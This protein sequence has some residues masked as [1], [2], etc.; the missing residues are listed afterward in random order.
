MST[1]TFS[2][3]K[4]L[5]NLIDSN[6]FD[7]KTQSN[8]KSNPGILNGIKEA[9]F[10]FLESCDYDAR[11]KVRSNIALKVLGKF[12]QTVKA[13]NLF[14][15]G[16]DF[17]NSVNWRQFALMLCPGIIRRTTLNGGNE[18]VSCKA[19]QDH[20]E[21][22][23]SGTGQCFS[24]AGPS[25]GEE[26]ITKAV[27]LDLKNKLQSYSKFFDFQP[28]LTDKP[29]AK[30]ELE[31]G[32]TKYL[33]E[34]ETQFK[35]GS[36]AVYFPLGYRHGSTNQGHAIVCKA[37]KDGNDIILKLFN[38]G[39][40]THLHPILGYTLN[41][42]MRSYSFLP[43][44]VS[45]TAFFGEM[46]KDAFCTL[47]RYLADAP[48]EN[49][50]H[51]EGE[52][53]YDVFCQLALFNQEGIV[54]H[55]GPHAEEY[56]ANEQ[57]SG[58]CPEIA[59][60]M[61]ITDV[62]IDHGVPKSQREKY[63]LNR[64]FCA[65]IAGYQALIKDPACHPSACQLLHD[66]TESFSQQIL[67]LYAKKEISEQELLCAQSV[68]RKIMESIAE[69]PEPALSILKVDPTK[70]F[71]N[72]FLM[73]PTLN[74]SI[75]LTDPHSS[76]HRISVDP[77]YFDA[78]GIGYFEVQLK[79]WIGTAQSLS[80][81][82]A[83]H[84]VADCIRKLPI[85][86][87]TDKRESGIDQPSLDVWNGIEKQKVK[88]ILAGFEELLRTGLRGVRV[89]AKSWG[90]DPILQFSDQFMMIYTVYAI[91]DKLARSCDEKTKLSGFASPFLPCP[92]TFSPD[93]FSSLPLKEDND[94]Y[95]KLQQYFTG[96]INPLEKNDS[97]EKVIFPVEPILP[98]QQY[99]EDMFKGDGERERVQGRNHIEYLSRHLKTPHANT[100]MLGK[101]YAE[102]W[103]SLLPEEVRSLY[104]FSFLSHLLFSAPGSEF[105]KEL[106]FSRAS[107]S[108]GTSGLRIENPFYQENKNKGPSGGN[109]KLYTPSHEPILNEAIQDDRFQENA[110]QYDRPIYNESDRF[111]DIY[112]KKY[113]SLKTNE[114]ICY[115]LS[116][117]DRDKWEISEA[118]IRTLLYITRKENLSLW[119]S[120]QEFSRPENQFLLSHTGVQMILES[121]F[122]RP[123][124]MI[125]GMQQEPESL[126]GAFR[127]FVAQ[128]LQYFDHHTSQLKGI[129]FLLRVGISFETFT[130]S[131]KSREETL[132]RYRK[133][134]KFLEE[135]PLNDKQRSEIF[136]HKAFLEAHSEQEDPAELFKI[137]FHAHLHVS[138]KQV[139]YPWL[140]AV[141]PRLIRKCAYQYHLSLTDEKSRNV[142]CRGIA[143]NCLNDYD[144]YNKL[145]L[146]EWKG[147][148]PQFECG[149]LILDFFNG[150]II[151]KKHGVLARLEE[152]SELPIDSH[153]YEDF[154]AEYGRLFWKDKKKGL[155]SIDERIQYAS[156]KKRLIFKNQSSNSENAEGEQLQFPILEIDPRGQA[157]LNYYQYLPWIHYKKSSGTV[158]TYDQKKQCPF[159][160]IDVSKKGLTYTRLNPDGTLL[161][162]QLANLSSLKQ[163]DY[164]YHYSARYAY[165]DSILCFVHEKTNEVQEV[166]FYRL[167]LQ[168][169]KKEHGL[170]S[171]QYPGF[172]LISQEEDLKSFKRESLKSVYGSLQEEINRFEGMM[173][174]Y[175]P[176]TDQ[177]ILLF[178]NVPLTHGQG[179][180]SREA[181]SNSNAS[182]PG[183]PPYFKY[184]FDAKEKG[185]RT[186][187]LENK[188]IF[189]LSV[190]F[191]MQRD[192]EK[193]SKY[194][195][196][197]K[198]STI[199]NS[200]DLYS[201]ERFIKIHDH[202]A[203]S[204]AF[205]LNLCLF[206]F[207][208]MNLMT[209]EHFQK[210]LNS[211]FYFNLFFWGMDNYKTY[212]H[213]LNESGQSRVPENLRIN[214]GDK[215]KLL[216][217]F[218]DFYEET[219]KDKGDWEKHWIKEQPILDNQYN[220]YFKRDRKN[221]VTLEPQELLLSPPV[222]SHISK[223]NKIKVTDSTEYLYWK[224]DDETDDGSLPG[225]DNSKL[226]EYPVRA[227]LKAICAGFPE[228]YERARNC[229]PGIPDPFDFTL[230]SLLKAHNKYSSSTP[231]HLPMLLFW[232]RHFSDKFQD[233]EFSLAKCSSD[234]WESLL[235]KLRIIQERVQSLEKDEE[236]YSSFVKTVLESKA[237]YTSERE[238]LLEARRREEHHIK[239]DLESSKGSS[240]DLT[241][242]QSEMQA[243]FNTPY[244]VKGSTLVPVSKIEEE[245]LFLLKQDGER[246]LSTKQEE[247]ASQIAETIMKQVI[248][249]NDLDY[250]F[251][252]RPMLSVEQMQ[253]LCRLANE[254]HYAKVCQKLREEGKN[255]IPYDYTKFP[256]I[257]YFY[258]KTGKFPRIEQLETYAWIC[259]GI[260]KGRNR[261]FQL[262]A[263]AG[264]TD[265]VIPLLNLGAKRWG[266]MPV[267]CVTQAIYPI[268][269]ANLNY[270]LSTLD[271]NLSYLEVGMHMI[272]SLS[273]KDL[274]FIYSQL[275]AYK[276][277]GRSLIMTRHTYDAIFLLRDL[278]CKAAGKDENEEER[279]N[280]I[281]WAQSILNFFEEECLL[282][283]DESHQN[284]D[285]LTRA[286]FGTGDFIPIPEEE[287]G[288]LLKLMKP[289]LG[290]YPENKVV[291][292]PSKKDVSEVSHFGNSET[293][294]RPT[295]GEMRE[296]QDALA[297]YY[298]SEIFTMI[299][300]KDKEEFKQY[301]TDQKAPQPALLK[302]WGN[303]K[304]PEDRKRASLIALTGNF[305]LTLLPDA[306]K[307][308]T[309]ID[310]ARS[311]YP[312]KSFDVPSHNKLPTTA[313]YESY[314]TTI[315]TIKGSYQ[316]GILKDDLR[317]MLEDM[318]KSSSD[319]KLKGYL[320]AE[321]PT[322]QRL[323]KW[324]CGSLLKSLCIEDIDLS[325]TQQ[326]QQLFTL[327]AK[328]RGTIEYFLTKYAFPGIGN[329]KEQLFSTSTDTFNGFKNVVA[330][331]ATPRDELVYPRC[332]EP[333]DFRKDDSFRKN[334]FT[335][336]LDPK[337]GQKIIVDK[338]DEIFSLDNLQCR[339]LL[340]SANV[341]IDPRG[342]FSTTHNQELAGKWLKAN[343]K[344]DG[345]LYCKEGRSEN[346]DRNEKICILLRD[347]TIHE[348]NGSTIIEALKEY[349]LDWETL[350]LGTIYDS[351]RTESANILQKKD[352]KALFFLGDGLTASHLVQAVMR[353]RGFLDKDQTVSWVVPR[354]LGQK[355]ADKDNGP[356]VSDI[357]AWTEDNEKEQEN[358]R[359]IINAF[360][361][362]AFA[363]AKQARNELK[364]AF[365]KDCMT[366]GSKME[367]MKETYR[368]YAWGLNE[369][370]PI[371]AYQAFGEHEV[372]KKTREALESFALT[373]YVRF[374]YGISYYSNENQSL[375][376]EVNAIISDVE[377]RIKEVYASPSLFVAAEVEQQQEMRTQKEKQQENQ[378]PRPMQ[379]RPLDGKYGDVEVYSPKFLNV[380]RELA[381]DFLESKFITDNLYFSLNQMITATAN[382]TE[383]A[384]P[385]DFFLIIIE[386][387]PYTKKKKIWADVD[388]NEIVAHDLND[389]L[390]S[391]KK[392]EGLTHTAF[393]ISASGQLVQKGL[394]ALTPDAREMQKILQSDWVRDLV[395]DA[396][397]L[398]GK[399]PKDPK[400]IDRILQRIK[401]CG[402]DEFA[403]LWDKILNSLPNVERAQIQA[404]ESLEKRYQKECLEE[405][406]PSLK[407]CQVQNQDALL[408]EIKSIGW[409]NFEEI[410][411]D[412][413]KQIK[414]GKPDET[415]FR[416]LKWRYQHSLQE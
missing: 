272:K 359:I 279:G 13:N 252:V 242:I 84:Y 310:H 268:D 401:K 146:E 40:G 66:A 304:N 326:M 116:E 101:M 32:A 167:N 406:F 235:P 399:I 209:E 88:E 296:M 202:S 265:V 147:T 51:Y 70:E 342:F 274:K 281:R 33:K 395:I 360:Q 412:N 405:K 313:E 89:A 337:N 143:K 396:A 409:D 75:K 380:K 234:S 124:W 95:T 98:V 162:Y 383:I 53:I 94:R 74:K 227:S 131:D 364:R 114:A 79:N 76:F 16:K 151:H 339:K 250:L 194:L 119:Q 48:M 20:V 330:F 255:L 189:H 408:Q 221:T 139:N 50:P 391:P 215:M 211:F 178:P 264:K 311:L 224:K 284:A 83:F 283:C 355:I 8:V 314:K 27:L 148:F 275:R 237:E 31:L 93:G 287:S 38:L 171:S 168:F 136:L 87:R 100:K 404:F 41:Q 379:S 321:T 305:L 29:T 294:G 175:N 63:F 247:A 17:A 102:E 90:N 239:V 19:A 292:G 204:V 394:G 251:K 343:P 7:A 327:L 159:M 271:E 353:L 400:D 282:I 26:K 185:I 238:F 277:E 10:S 58:D 236:R 24:W 336:L 179:D 230:H 318:I 35:S 81:E 150:T 52:D 145:P 335:K 307:M 320:T 297:N 301:W 345:I 156:E 366:P 134:L 397:L 200:E 413:L 278:A 298:L 190:L 121:A 349:H 390:L 347:G 402:W 37:V 28:P 288:L 188:A 73:L 378:C 59:M 229:K 78:A 91:G 55:L 39:N 329:P 22:C 331:S 333:Q 137:L 276:S 105:P 246:I 289:L 324:L 60:R 86:I 203:A 153:G 172:Y 21:V 367:S 177:W 346:V 315:L 267:S 110:T 356:E 201:L 222:F 403:K 5:S 182:S 411:N 62:L 129:L 244:R 316:R 67:D 241:S 256:E 290:V 309:D 387:N 205:N 126:S 65:L 374:S 388:S 181:F 14:A 232:V 248:L 184:E 197:V 213:L 208:N 273:S 85:P 34:I 99:V 68:V 25:N 334:V 361:E 368:K 186:L 214:D 376:A 358:T 308:R 96:K 97:K 115:R 192:Y 240:Q 269:K 30:T 259:E 407:N 1:N 195:K 107:L 113:R 389:L 196:K 372:L 231:P 344:L 370:L 122:F 233:D 71:P 293:Q 416:D 261:H 245:T 61:I 218:R 9:S 82:E 104:Y 369:R 191:K 398:K 270:N 350:N 176:E 415:T 42:Q 410:W 226:V 155:V 187:G 142:I 266:L 258:L 120:L 135:G 2:L 365:R 57:I 12:G 149:D 170:I 180:F 6:P 302:Q 348:L 173:T 341:I 328:H 212:L 299:P 354:S 103:M 3:G 393:F 392:V 166:N 362:I 363:I 198:S 193:A 386:Q 133:T 123:H 243:L 18:R 338:N 141:I 64:D 56:A 381:C 225:S 77:P 223:P 125:Q 165:H 217:A 257:S 377:K 384:K 44:R 312:E 357:L 160:R 111:L 382:G 325:N 183:S 15:T 47:L 373:A 253:H 219:Y 132:E 280:K 80:A 11:T 138:K 154:L 291:C 375:R 163:A 49:E 45:E 69:I 164:L 109:V 161:P 46:G 54:P 371:D 92:F 207:R 199:F 130:S 117:T 43:I 340:E 4:I 108:D 174:L 332:I 262:P 414:T 228:L 263:G 319:E 72:E 260:G 127:N 300:N 249:K 106:V 23:L 216:L 317:K 285:P 352:A 303:S 112:S 169:T 158:I 144:K 206:I 322:N 220:V 306:V 157:F 286:I 118:D 128:G 323:Q 36:K 351:A 152:V 210:P 295:E 140:S 385:I 254:W